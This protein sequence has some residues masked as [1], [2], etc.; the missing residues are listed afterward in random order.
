MNES[1]CVMT[2]SRLAP[3]SILTL[4]AGREPSTKVHI[5]GGVWSGGLHLHIRHQRFESVEASLLVCDSQ[6]D[7][8]RP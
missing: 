8:T 1:K 2:G 6:L 4:L 7:H 3:P 5:P